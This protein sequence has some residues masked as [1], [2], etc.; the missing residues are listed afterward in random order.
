MD[1]TTPTR[2]VC[3][4]AFYAKHVS[5]ITGRRL[6]RL[7]LDEA[8]S[9]AD[10]HSLGQECRLNDAVW[11]GSTSGSTGMPKYVATEQRVW[12][13]LAEAKRLVMAL[14]PQDKFMN[15]QAFYYGDPMLV[16]RF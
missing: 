14:D 13:R 3:T 5:P 12:L 4:D 2:L 9:T 1:A 6:Q 8:A 16:S 15:S 11:L 7:F 10:W